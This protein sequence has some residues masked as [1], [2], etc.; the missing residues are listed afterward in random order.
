MSIWKRK[1]V[2]IISALLFMLWLAGQAMFQVFVVESPRPAFYWLNAAN[3]MQ[4]LAAIVMS[5]V[6]LVTNTRRPRGIDPDEMS[7]M[8]RVDHSTLDGFALTPYE[9][10]QHERRRTPPDRLPIDS[11]GIARHSGRK[12]HVV[13]DED[14]EPYGRR[15]TDIPIRDLKRVISAIQQIKSAGHDPEKVIDLPDWARQLHMAARGGQSPLD[16]PSAEPGEAAARQE[17][18]E[19]D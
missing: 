5:A 14:G 19:Q 3:L 12:K 8:S 15:V 6:L 2:Y 9:L 4:L 7:P 10:L 11:T 16:A 13:L 1:W 18:A 17:V